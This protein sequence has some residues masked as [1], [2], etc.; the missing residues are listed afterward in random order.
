M[1]EWTGKYQATHSKPLWYW[2]IVAILV[3]QLV[4]GVLIYFSTNLL[5]HPSGDTIE[6]HREMLPQP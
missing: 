5:Y 2:V 6:E 1:F 4:G 3:G